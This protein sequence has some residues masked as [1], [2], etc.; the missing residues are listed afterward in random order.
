MSKRTWCRF[1]YCFPFCAAPKPSWSRSIPLTIGSR[2]A[3]TRCSFYV[4]TLPD[5]PSSTPLFR[6]SQTVSKLAPEA[7]GLSPRDTSWAAADGGHPG[8]VS[9]R[10]PRS[11]SSEF[12]DSLGRLRRGVEEGGPGDH[13]DNVLGSKCSRGMR[14]F[15]TEAFRAKSSARLVERLRP[16]KR[17]RQVSWAPPRSH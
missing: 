16:P 7:P 13:I 2:F 6:R 9:G 5:P 11:F 1:S 8:V 17:G 10:G 3:V 4:R 15:Q 14:T 12:R